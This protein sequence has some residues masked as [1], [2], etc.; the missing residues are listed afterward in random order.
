M[1]DVN[2]FKSSL[3]MAP[4]AGYT[5]KIFRAICYQCGADYAFSEMISAYAL[6]YNDK[7][8]YKMLERADNEKVLFIQLFGHDIPAMVAAAKIVEKAGADVI[9]I[10]CGCPAP[11]VTSGGSG[12]ALLRDSD[13]LIDMIRQIKVA[14]QIPV[15]VKMRSGFLSSNR[16]FLE[17]GKRLEEAGVSAITLH[18]RTKTEMFSSN[19]NYDEIQELKKALRIPVIGNGDVRDY[20]SF[21]RM[22]KTDCDG[23]MIGRAALANP[24]IFKE[25]KTTSVVPV[26]Q[27]LDIAIKHINSLCDEYGARGILLSRSIACFHLRAFPNSAKLRQEAVACKTCDE[28]LAI[29]TALKQQIL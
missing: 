12:S 13:H 28:F 8:T 7:E 6:I 27:K 29:F 5:N 9:D 4:L 14:V 10:N 20:P 11:K 2:N 23:V 22:K 1:F 3:I 19:A 25:L 21:Q 26:E 24:F 18:P 16:N 17:L 15:T